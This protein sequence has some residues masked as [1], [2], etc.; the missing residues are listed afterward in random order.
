MQ[1]NMHRIN[2]EI[3]RSDTSDNGVKIRPVTIEIAASLVQSIGNLNDIALKQS[4]CVRIGQHNR[5]NVIAQLV[6][7]SGKVNTTVR[8]GRDFINFKAQQSRCR[9]IGPM[10][11]FRH[12][13]TAAGFQLAARFNRRTYRHHAA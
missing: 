11:G 3:S 13:D 7:K 5:G 12:K 9:R 1:I 6:L 4:A 10:R 2:A 8:I